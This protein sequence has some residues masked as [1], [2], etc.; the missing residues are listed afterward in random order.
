[1]NCT[2]SETIL[3]LIIIIFGCSSGTVQRG[4]ALVLETTAACAF[5]FL[6]EGNVEFSFIFGAF[7]LVTDIEYVAIFMR[8]IGLTWWVT[9]KRWLRPTLAHCIVNNALNKWW[10]KVLGPQTVHI[11]VQTGAED[12]MGR[13]CGLV[14]HDTGWSKTGS[15]MN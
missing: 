2:D 3:L 10:K 8:T 12:A 14:K 1:M 5:V 15:L 6:N 4:I 9:K 11:I 7:M 13:K